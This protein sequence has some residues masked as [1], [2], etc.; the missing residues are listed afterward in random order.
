M[1]F[2]LSDAEHFVTKNLRLYLRNPYY[3]L[4]GLDEYVFLFECSIVFWLLLMS[5]AG[6]IFV[7]GIE[8]GRRRI[9]ENLIDTN[10][11][12]WLRSL[13]RMC[14]RREITSKYEEDVLLKS[15]GDGYRDVEAFRDSKMDEEKLIS[16][17]A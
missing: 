2:S 6:F 13:Q 8:R 5:T 12:R 1:A 16:F 3:P 17:D 11:E 15:E 7:L 14:S 9:L 4:N 10:S